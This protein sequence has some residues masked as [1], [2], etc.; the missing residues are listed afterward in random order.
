MHHFDNHDRSNLD[1]DLVVHSIRITNDY[2][3]E[4]EKQCNRLI[5]S[6]ESVQS[7]RKYNGMSTQLQI[8]RDWDLIGKM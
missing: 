6:I 3:S 8:Q 1:D 7:K 2:Y 4:H 5:A